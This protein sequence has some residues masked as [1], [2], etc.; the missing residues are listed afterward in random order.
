MASVEVHA[1]AQLV[2]ENEADAPE[3]RPERENVIDWLVPEERDA[4]MVPAPVVPW[5]REMVPELEREK[6]NDAGGGGGGGVGDD[7]VVAD[8]GEDCAEALPA[9]SMAE[10]V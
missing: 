5:V 6:S 9:A 2:G 10:T 1:G 4:V 7:C 8:A 3:G